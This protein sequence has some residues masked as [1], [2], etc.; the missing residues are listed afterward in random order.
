[1]IKNIIKNRLT[2]L[3]LILFLIFSGMLYYY[4]DAV[5]NQ[6][7]IASTAMKTVEVS[8]QTIRKEISGSGEISSSVQENIAPG[9]YK[10][11]KEVYVEENQVVKKG[12]K[13]LK[14]TDGTFLTA[15]YDLAINSIHLGMIGKPCNPDMDYIEVF[16]LQDLQITLNVDETDKNSIYTGQE[17][18]IKANAAEENSF[19]GTVQKIDAIG[20]YDASGSS[21]KVVVTFQNDGSLSIG[22]SGLCQ[23][24]VA[25][26]IDAIAVPIEAVR[27]TESENF[28][29]VL[30]EDGTTKEVKVEIGLSNDQYVEIKS[31]LTFG[32][33][34]QYTPVHE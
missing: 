27:T 11:L 28:V 3:V 32:Q 1:M 23:I 13:L 12:E 31:G 9:K 21:F 7:A 16:G 17:V 22:M 18:V 20:K 14:Y 26:A 29:T 8:K 10:T 6:D 4:M 30:N 19:K 34:I 15:P 25:E 5:N 24:T 2:L 33:R